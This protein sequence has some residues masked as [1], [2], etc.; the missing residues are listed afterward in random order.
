MKRFSDQTLYEILEVPAWVSRSEIQR[1]YE[2][3][4]LTF[5]DGAIASYSLF[6]PEELAY[7]REKIEHAYRTLSDDALRRA[8]D[9]A[10]PPE[11]WSGRPASAP[12]ARSEECVPVESRDIGK[13]AIV[14]EEAGYSGPALRQYRQA[15][16]VT[17]DQIHIATRIGV[18]Q[19]CAIEDED[20][21]GL[22]HEVYLK[23]Y[24]VQYSRQLG[25][26]PETVAKGYLARRRY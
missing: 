8:Y 23:A 24:L 25:L 14:L 20:D 17:L 4:R 15:L 26:N 22:P 3:L 16:G 19:L 5:E 2:L 1:A 7:I 13:A 12:S 10:L 18:P 21:S 9:G 6:T 11:V